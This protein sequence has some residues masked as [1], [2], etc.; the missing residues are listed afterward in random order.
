M[1]KRRLLSAHLEGEQPTLFPLETSIE[2]RHV[3]EVH[4]IHNKR[5]PLRY[6][7][8][9]VQV[10]ACGCWRLSWHDP[11]GKQADWKNSDVRIALIR[12]HEAMEEL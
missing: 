1:V 11:V 6:G 8:S 10:C 5:Y 12:A 2:P 7:S 3:H 9:E 4:H